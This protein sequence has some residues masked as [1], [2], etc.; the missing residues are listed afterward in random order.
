M[1]LSHLASHL[2]NKKH[3][4]DPLGKRPIYLSDTESIRGSAKN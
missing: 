2:T 1:F 4:E 3:E